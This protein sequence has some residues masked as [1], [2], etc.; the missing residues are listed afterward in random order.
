MSKL[1]PRG[2]VV[3]GAAAL[4]WVEQSPERKTPEVSI[5]LPCLNEAQTLGVCIA[6]AKATIEKHRLNAEI[7]VA[8]NGSTDASEEIARRS[9]ARVVQATR[10]GYGAA[11]MAGIEAA[12]GEFVIIGDA[13]DSYDFGAIYPFIEKLRE[14]WDLAMGCRLPGGGGTIAPGAMPWKHRWL[15]NPVLSALGRLFFRSRVTDFHCG[16]RGFRRAAYLALDL[17][18]TGMEFASEMIVKATLHGLQITEIPITLHKDGRD[19][20]PHLRSWR[21][22]WRHLRFMLLYSPAWLFLIPGAVLLVIGT[23][24]SATL[25]VGAVHIHGIGFDT[26]TLLVAA[27]T[28]ILGYQVVV[29]GVISKVFAISEGLRPPD[30]L[31]DRGCRVVNLEVG[32]AAG[33]FLVLAGFGSLLGALLYWRSHGYG[34]LNYSVSQR[35]IIPGVTGIVLGLQTMFSSFLLSVFGLAR[36]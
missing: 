35:L 36:K 25:V 22:G 34:V 9:G 15:G 17:Q 28:V 4:R 3:G 32:I 23:V 6:K 20:P 8:D 24:V 2:G 31:L 16:L 13:D 14:G 30:P 26:S 7:I 33:L 11:L 12:A 10:K 29:F 1:Q 21:D 18:T 5:V 19:R 27:M